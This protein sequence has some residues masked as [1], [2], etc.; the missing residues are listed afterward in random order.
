MRSRRRWII[1]GAALVCAPF[2]IAATWLSVSAFLVPPGSAPRFRGPQGREGDITE[3]LATAEQTGGSLGLFRQ[4]IAP[5]SGPPTHVHHGEDEFFYIVSG[6]FK[7]KVGDRIVNAPPQSVMFVPRGTPHTFQ[8]TG[9]G[10]GVLLVGVTPGGFEKMFRERAGAD[11]ETNRKL[12]H[13]RH[14]EVVGPPLK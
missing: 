13:D 10:D 14:M 2:V 4:R 7:V 8:N 6:N 5:N 9:R 11:A 1:A 12:M 3:I